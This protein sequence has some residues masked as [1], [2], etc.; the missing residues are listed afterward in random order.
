M[1]KVSDTNANAFGE[2]EI[3]DKNIKF[4]LFYQF[5]MAFVYSLKDYAIFRTCEFLVEA[6]FLL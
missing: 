2:N 3:E 6:K 5:F 4:F 1:K